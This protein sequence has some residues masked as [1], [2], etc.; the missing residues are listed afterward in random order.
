MDIIIEF[1]IFISLLAFFDRLREII[2]F[3]RWFSNS[4]FQRL[5]N[6][7]FKLYTWLQSYDS[8][9]Y[10]YYILTFKHLT[11]KFLL[12]PIFWDGQ[13]FFK[14][15][16]VFIILLYISLK[17]YNSIFG[18]FLS[19]LMMSCAWYFIQ[20]VTYKIFVQKD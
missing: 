10:R 14:N 4:I 18:I 16:N 17:S 7:Y 2:E 12:H 19:I 9:E 5:K 6:K 8:N 15:I 20:T 1:L 3:D 13:H 11:I